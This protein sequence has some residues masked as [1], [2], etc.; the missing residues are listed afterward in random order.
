[1]YS[2]AKYSGAPDIVRQFC[3]LYDAFIVGGSAKYLMGLTEECKDWDVIVPLSK[4]GQAQKLIPKAA[5][6]NTF[7]GSKI[8]VAHEVGFGY[9]IFVQIDVWS[10]DLS[11]YLYGNM[12]TETYIVHPKSLFSG[13]FDYGFEKNPPNAKE[14]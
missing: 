13:R 3:Q 9:G 12:H 7:G 1:M 8:E 10:C 11:E 6:H 14:S 2:Y 4:W 5:T